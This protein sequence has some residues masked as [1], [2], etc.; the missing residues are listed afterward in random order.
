MISRLVETIG[1]LVAVGEIVCHSNGPCAAQEA[2]TQAPTIVQLSP[3]APQLPSQVHEPLTENR[4]PVRGAELGKTI[5]LIGRLGKPMTEVVELRGHWEDRGFTKASRFVLIVTTRIS[6]ACWMPARQ[7]RAG[8][9]SSW[10]WSAA[11]RSP[12][13]ATSIT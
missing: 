3:G 11:C 13:I 1:V 6:P 2:R 4:L 7:A 12:A 10:T 9:I 5:A 8:R